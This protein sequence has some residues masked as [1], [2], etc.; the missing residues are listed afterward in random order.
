MEVETSE[1]STILSTH[2]WNQLGA[3]MNPKVTWK[4]IE[5]NIPPFSPTTEKCQLCIREKFNIELRPEYATLNVR[6]EIFSSCRHREGKLLVK[7]P[8]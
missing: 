7:A 6:H 3:G 5:K 8:D 4:V 2:F 1:N